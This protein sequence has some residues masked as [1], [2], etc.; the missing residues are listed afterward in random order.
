MVGCRRLRGPAVS[1]G[2]SVSGSLRI[3]D[4]DYGTGLGT[5]INADAAGLCSGGFKD[6]YGE[7]DMMR[8]EAGQEEKG[9]QRSRYR[10]SVPIKCRQS[11]I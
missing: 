4:G 1:T 11:R 6:V 9:I 2:R 5:P 10:L 8:Q 7:Q 3:A